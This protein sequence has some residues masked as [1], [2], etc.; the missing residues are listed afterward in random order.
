MLFASFDRRRPFGLLKHSGYP[1]GVDFGVASLKVLQVAP[2]A[3]DEDPLVL[4]AAAAL[5]TP[6]DLLTDHAKR[7]AFQ[8]E[9]LPKLIRSGEFRGKRA[10]CSIPAGQTFCKHMQFPRTDGLTVASLVKAAVPAQI[11]CHPDALIYRHIEVDASSG[12]P[13]ANSGKN[14]V[15]C[16][17]A[18]RKLIAQFMKAV[19]DARLEPVAMHPECLAT[20]RGFDQITRRAEDTA[21]TTLYLDIGMGATKVM[22][23]HGRDLVFAKAINLAGAQLDA[24]VAK[25]QQVGAAVARARRINSQQLIPSAKAVNAAPA[26]EPG[27][28]MAVLAAGM[29]MAREEAATEG[30]QR[31]A[32]MAAAALAEERRTARI[33]PGLT[34][35]LTSEPASKGPRAP[36]DIDLSQPL[37]ALTDEV[38]MCLR[39]H[40]ALFPGRRVNRTI[41]VGGESRHRGL[42]QH[43]AR[44]LRVPAQVADPFARLA[45]TGQEK[46]PG[47]DLT[48]PQPGWAVPFGLCVA[49]TDL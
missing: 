49:P 8:T 35:D 4:V 48:S 40:E 6:E 16:L 38:A 7:I 9:N 28:G 42:C 19:R 12:N 17:A 45:R 21:L 44:T 26:G 30:R 43:I 10:V 31:P 3:K 33:A 20:L 39:Y 47:V 14:E 11:G 27:D 37:E 15:I 25:R 18:S 2:G 22:I 29:V 13:Q 5:E 36:T 1:I 32:E 46:T 41:F 24:A 34:H 23:A